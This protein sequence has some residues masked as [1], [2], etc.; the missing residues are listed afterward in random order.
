MRIE[1]LYKKSEALEIA[2]GLQ[3]HCLVGKPP[4]E[5]IMKLAEAVIAQ[6]QELGRIQRLPDQ[7]W[8]AVGAILLRI[9][10]KAAR[11]GF[12]VKETDAV[13]AIDRGKVYV[14]RI[15]AQ[16]DALVDTLV[17]LFGWEDTSYAHAL[18]HVENAVNNLRADAAVSRLP[19][20]DD[21]AF[22]LCYV[23]DSWAYFTTQDVK[24][25]WGDDWNDAPYEHNA[26]TPYLPHEH[27]IEAG[28]EPWEIC[29]VAWEGPF[30][31][32]CDGHV[33]SPYSVEQINSGAVAWLRTAS[34]ADKQIAIMA[35]TT[36]KDFKHYILEAG[37]SVFIHAD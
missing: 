21:L 14:D 35:G 13:A 33:N 17:K 18:L 31:T 24:E 22:K 2:E 10:A 23:E 37:G 11:D 9:L 16:R 7:E 12:P 34:Y 25:Q 30:W 19:S 1:D 32:P 36:L 8:A 4:M 6:S 15:L 5:S 26:G 20:P 29:S 27:D 28:K 3:K